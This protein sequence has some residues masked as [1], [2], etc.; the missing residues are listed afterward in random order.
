VWAGSGAGAIASVGDC[1]GRL[2]AVGDS[3]GRS[4]VPLS[5]SVGLGAVF[6]AGVV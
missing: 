3:A 6:E 5:H 4:K 1:P 2:S